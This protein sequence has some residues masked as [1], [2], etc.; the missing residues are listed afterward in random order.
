MQNDIDSLKK[1]IDK[2]KDNPDFLLID[3]REDFEYKNE[4]IANSKLLPLSQIES[5]FKKLKKDKKYIIYCRSGNRSEMV[6]NMMLK[7]GFKDVV[8]LDGG[9]L[10]WKNNEFETIEN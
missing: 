7:E 1:I 4:R 9:I 6:V 3:V 10:A 2:N 5:W 8:N